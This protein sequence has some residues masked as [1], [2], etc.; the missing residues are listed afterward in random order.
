MARF[1]VR[2]VMATILVMIAVSIVTFLLF[3]QVVSN[4]ATLLAGRLANPAEVHLIDVKYGF[5]K[6]IYT[7]YAKTMKNIF[8]GEAYSYQS[9]FNVLDE[10]E[11]GLPRTIWLAVGAGVFWLLT[12]ILFGTLAAIRSGKYTDRVLT[13]LSMIGVSMPP[14]FLGAIIIYYIGYKANLL[15]IGGYTPFAQSPWEWFKHLLAPWFTLSVLFIGFY[16]RVLRSTILDTVNEDYVRTAR[17]KGLS[18]RR[19]L[20]RHVLR[21]SLI[22][23][24][25]LFGLDFA[26]L[27]GGGAII[28]ETVYNIHGVGQLAADSI[29]HQDLITL[30]AIV[31]LTAFFVVVLGALTD[32]LYAYLDPRIRLS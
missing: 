6:P 25:S 7:Q 22:P 30:M 5:D 28:T 18:P 26:Q 10:I 11:T 15:P 27:I 16:S 8:T 9:G 24:F 21:N 13:V 12:S 4:P 32:I 14:F 2:R 23:I 20:F 29:G 3:T 19:V 17:A 1:F 31:M